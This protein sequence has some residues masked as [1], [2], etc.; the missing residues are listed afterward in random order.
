MWLS[1]ISQ[2]C[3]SI[4]VR[5]EAQQDEGLGAVT[6]Y[7]DL[8]DM[9]GALSGFRRRDEVLTPEYGSGVLALCRSGRRRVDQCWGVG[10]PR[11]ER[12]SGH[13]SRES[14]NHRRVDRPHGEIVAE[15]LSRLGGR[16]VD[17][18]ASR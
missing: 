5:V 3:R 9:S 17:M 13:A 4:A 18:P 12:H 7:A 8:V 16:V 15:G 6:E 10:G 2:S 11:H 1:E 14:Q